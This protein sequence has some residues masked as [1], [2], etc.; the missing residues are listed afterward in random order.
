MVNLVERADYP[1]NKR[2]AKAIFEGDYKFNVLQRLKRWDSRSASRDGISFAGTV[3]NI[4]GQEWARREKEIT[5]LQNDLRRVPA[6]V[7]AERIIDELHKEGLIE[8][9]NDPKVR[10]VIKDWVK[11]IRSDSIAKQENW[12]RNEIPQYIQHKVPSPWQRAFCFLLDNCFISTDRLNFGKERDRLIDLYRR[13]QADPKAGLNE[14]DKHNLIGLANFFAFLQINDRQLIAEL[15]KCLATGKDNELR[16]QLVKIVRWTP[17]NEPEVVE[18]MKALLDSPRAFDRLYALGYLGKAAGRLYQSDRK[19]GEKILELVSSKLDEIITNGS[20][21]EQ[22]EIVKFFLG[23]WDARQEHHRKFLFRSN[24]AVEMLFNLAINIEGQNCRI[25]PE[26]RRHAIKALQIF[27]SVSPRARR[28]LKTI[29]SEAP[30]LLMREEAIIAFGKEPPLSPLTLDISPGEEREAHAGTLEHSLNYGGIPEP[31][32]DGKDWQSTGLEMGGASRASV[33]ITDGKYGAKKALPPATL[34]YP[35]PRVVP[36]VERL[37]SSL[38]WV[39]GLSTVSKIQISESTSGGEYVSFFVGPPPTESEYALVNSIG[40][41]LEDLRELKGRIDEYNH[42]L[43]LDE[44][45]LNLEL[46]YRSRIVGDLTDLD[47]EELSDLKIKRI[48]A[49]NPSGTTFSFSV[50]TAESR[51]EKAEQWFHRCHHIFTN[52]ESLDEIRFLDWITGNEDRLGYHNILVG[53]PPDNPQVHTLHYIDFAAAFRFLQR[54]GR[55][56]REHHQRFRSNLH[57]ALAEAP[58]IFRQNIMPVAVRF[59][60]LPRTSLVRLVG[61]IKE[62]QLAKPEKE[63]LLDLLIKEQEAVRDEFLSWRR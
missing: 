2:I 40:R 41:S 34:K 51:N 22:M 57:V 24:L 14:E 59:A 17:T 43:N 19:K 32:A 28:S 38:G 63:G 55:D 49:E 3:I 42:P 30:L 23:D 45:S 36:G 25:A 31:Y 12:I 27:S 58:Q 18:A 10:R 37:V 50:E 11:M 52:P 9:K 53:H 26:V 47:S 8:E 35:N 15:V 61:E 44:F 7:I 16:W 60:L 5:K 6:A 20:V 33:V 39:L 13:Y 29:A 54:R 21:S 56:W 48:I 1:G 62:P 4:N 46:F